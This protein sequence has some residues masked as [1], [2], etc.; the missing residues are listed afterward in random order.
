MLKK[1]SVKN[2]IVKFTLYIVWK[3]D[4]IS[5]YINILKYGEV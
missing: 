1:Q 4:E 2:Y 5:M 3:M